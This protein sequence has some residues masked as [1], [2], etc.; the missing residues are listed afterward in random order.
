VEQNKKIGG[1]HIALALLTV[2]FLVSLAVLKL[3]GEANVTAAEG[4]RV[5]AERR[6][7]AEQLT[8]PEREPVNVNT[9]DA[10]ELEAL[11]GIG[12]V[13]AQRIVDYRAAHGAF[14]SEEQLMEVEGIGRAKLDGFRELIT[15]GEEEAP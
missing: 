4:Y 7:P 1:A 9:A 10:E 13:L 11:P 8:V 12:A 3:Y 6:V 14:A 2:V 5:A 15:L